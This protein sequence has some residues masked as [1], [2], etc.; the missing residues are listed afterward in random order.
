MAKA[1]TYGT[2]ESATWLWFQLSSKICQQLPKRAQMDLVELTIVQPLSLCVQPA[3]NVPYRR[4]L[5][6]PCQGNLAATN[7]LGKPLKGFIV[8]PTDLP[9][10]GVKRL[11][12]SSKTIN[13]S[14]RV[15]MY[16][17][18]RVLKTVIKAVLTVTSDLALFRSKIFWRIDTIA[19]SF[20]FDKYCSIMD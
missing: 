20:V 3:W 17:L 5:Y 11:A 8:K 4:G 13:H 12:T 1:E 6:N 10:K 15:K 14:S 18:C 7:L 2:T 16:K 9:R 19:L